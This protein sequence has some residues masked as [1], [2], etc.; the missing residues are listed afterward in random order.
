VDTA[1]CYERLHDSLGKIAPK[2]Q[3]GHHWSGQVIE[4]NDGLPFIGESD[5]GQFISTGFSGNGMTF[6]TLAAMMASDWV[7]QK[8]N[9]WTDLFAPSRKKLKGGVWDY[10]KENVDYPYY[11]M[12]TRLAAAEGDSLASVAKNE[13]KI[14][15]L[16][17]KKVA[18]YRDA[19]GAVTKR[20]AVCTHMGCIVRWNVA[21]NTWDCPCHGSRFKPDGAVISGPAE[22][23]LASS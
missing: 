6:G 18:V 19:D 21:E 4:T 10:L 1:R 11:L 7:A 8:K 9:P 12:K 5:P 17:G 22:A 14:V 3:V 20:S 15:R 23:P 16:H 2:A 13:G